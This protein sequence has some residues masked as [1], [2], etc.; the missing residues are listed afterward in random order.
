MNR[1][2]M[3]VV[4]GVFEIVSAVCALVGSGLLLFATAFLGAIPEVRNDPEVPVEIISAL[5]LGIGLFVLS[6]GLVSVI[7]GVCGVRRR[8][9]GWTLAGSVAALFIVAPAGILALVSTLGGEKE[10]RERAA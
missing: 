6:L 3:P 7:G 5:L 9:W 4:A 2:W 1:E 8:R 10:F